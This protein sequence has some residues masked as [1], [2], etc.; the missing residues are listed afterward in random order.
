MFGW[1]S[2]LFSHCSHCEH[3]RTLIRERDAAIESE[4]KLRHEIEE[5]HLKIR[6]ELHAV[7]NELATLQAKVWMTDAQREAEKIKAHV[8]AAREQLTKPLEGA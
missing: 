6:A 3:L 7:R 1:L 5:R 4:R 8:A 2:N